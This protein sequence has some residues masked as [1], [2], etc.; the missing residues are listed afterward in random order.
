[1]V[2]TGKVEGEAGALLVKVLM[3]IF[4]LEIEKLQLVDRKIT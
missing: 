1:V 4:P 3:V 2:G